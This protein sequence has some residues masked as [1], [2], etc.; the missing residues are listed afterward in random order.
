MHTQ[1]KAAPEQRDGFDNLASPPYTDNDLAAINRA[2]TEE[3]G[4]APVEPTKVQ[5]VANDIANLLRLRP[6]LRRVD[7]SH[8]L[9]V[10]KSDITRAIQRLQSQGRALDAL[11]RPWSRRTV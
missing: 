8:A 11:A 3:L 6:G 2:A 9:N 10:R 4:I 1:E 7:L 5:R